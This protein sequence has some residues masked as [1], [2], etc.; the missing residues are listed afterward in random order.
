MIE[1]F[2]NANREAIVPL[3]LRGP[4]GQTRE[5]NAVIDTGYSGALTLPHA[6]V[7]ELEL[8]YV[9]SSKATLADD[10]EVG[11]RRRRRP[12]PHGRLP[13]QDQGTRPLPPLRLRQRRPRPPAPPKRTGK[14]WL[15]STTQRAVR[16]GV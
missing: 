4:E 8:P 3:S 7:A 10:T 11:F 14:P 16:T 13:P 9:F 1:G 2:V 12:P 5:V 6:L 15:P